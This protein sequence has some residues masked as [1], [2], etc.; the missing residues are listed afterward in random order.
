MRAPG[1][2]RLALREAASAFVDVGAT[3]RTLGQRACVG[4]NAARVT[5]ENMLR[6]G[7]LRVLGTVRVPGVSRPM[8]LLAPRAPHA[9]DAPVGGHLADVVRCWADFK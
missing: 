2:I 7:E 3:W 8:A 9:D 5:A 4:A 1:E 6:A